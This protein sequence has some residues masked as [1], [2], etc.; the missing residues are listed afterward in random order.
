MLAPPLE[1]QLL[2]KTPIWTG[3]AN[4]KMAD[5]ILETGIVGSLR[6][7]VEAIVRSAGFHVPEDPGS[8]SISPAANLFGTTEGKRQFAFS[9][10]DQTAPDPHLQP[11]RGSSISF[12][13]DEKV[14]IGPH[15]DEKDRLKYPE[16]VFQG[17]PRGGS[18]AIRLRA[19]QTHCAILQSALFL[20]SRVGAIGAKAQFGCGVFDLCRH[21]QDHSKIHDLLNPAYPGAPQPETHLNAELPTLQSLFWKEIP[22]PGFKPSVNDLTP[23]LL[24]YRIREQIRIKGYPQDLRHQIC[25]WVRNPPSGSIFFISF[26]F[27]RNDEYRIRVWGWHPLGLA[28]PRADLLDRIDDGIQ[29]H[30]PAAPRGFHDLGLSRARPAT[31]DEIVA[32]L[33]GL[34]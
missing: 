21:P 10:D 12:K 25:G 7:W 15:R 13:L 3:D 5:H 18:L 4:G 29:G 31:P 23:F 20:A 14:G 6:W 17:H 26:P 11:N 1:I 2:T 16:W 30:I 24:R 34:S 8:D 19:S 33:G 27:P 28:L 9:I 22:L 32:A